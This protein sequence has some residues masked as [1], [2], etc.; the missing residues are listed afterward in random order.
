MIVA[1]A[2][3]LANCQS[4]TAN[5]FINIHY[6]NDARFYMRKSMIKMQL[7]ILRLVNLKKI[8]FIINYKTY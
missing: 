8:N 2:K 1:P 7:S 5:L 3:T 6:I 4:K